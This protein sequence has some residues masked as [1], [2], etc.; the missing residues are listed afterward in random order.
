MSIKWGI[1][2]CGN[3]TEVKSGPAFNNIPNS[4]LV[5]VMRRNLELAK[6]YAKRHNVPKYYNNVDDLINDPEV[7][8]IYIGTPPAFHKE[9][10]I[11]CAIAKKPVYIE[12]PMALT[13]QECNE[14]IDIC[15]INKV[16]LFVAYYFPSLPKFIK[17]KEL[18]GEIGEVLYVNY[19]IHR[20]PNNTQSWRNDPAISGGG[21]FMDIGCHV[22]HLLEFLLGSI[23]KIYAYKSCQ[24]QHINSSSVENC[25]S[26][27][28]MFQNGI[29]GNGLW[30]FNSYNRY[31]NMDIVGTEGKIS[32]SILNNSSIILETNS[33][34]TEYFYEEPKHVQQYLIENIVESLINNKPNNNYL[35][36]AKV[37]YLMDQ[38]YRNN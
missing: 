6:D 29:H 21:L 16:P 25:V 34:K 5:A 24:L 10:A 28:F 13:F 12:K 14:I 8:A 32:F 2:G 20:P 35:G 22:L 23:E 7:N 36:A 17:I 31:E 11:K 18:L 9:Y 27:S 33:D 4:Q 3:V 19:V 38:I 30:N 26:T 1:I 37:N 15:N